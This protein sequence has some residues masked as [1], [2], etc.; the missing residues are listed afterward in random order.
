MSDHLSPKRAQLVVD[1]LADQQS[2][3]VDFLRQLTRAESPSDVPAT[4]TA[5]LHLLEVFLRSID[6]HVE[7]VAG[8]HTGG[9]LV[10]QP[11]NDADRPQQLLVGHCDTVWPDGTLESMPAE[12]N[13]GRMTGPGVYDMKSGLV[14]MLFALKALKELDIDMELSPLVFINTDEEIGSVESRE[15]VHELAQRVQRAFVLE[16]SMGPSGKLKTTRKGV[17]RF[18]VTVKGKAAHAG[19]D[20]ESGASAIAELAVV[21]QQLFSLNDVAA[22][23]TVNVGMIEGGVRPNVIAPESKAVVDVR[24]RSITE[25]ARVEN[26]IRGLQPTTTDT[27]IHVSGGMGRPPMEPT[28][29][30]QQLW[31]L[32]RDLGGLIG[33]ELEQ[34]AAGGGSDGNLTSQHTA[35]LDGLGGVGDGAHAV[36]EFVEVEE[37]PRRCALLALLLAAPDL[38]NQ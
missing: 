38:A 19:L 27:S 26:A 24:V 30:N 8:V 4:Q 35:T 22:G 13:E 12:V 23:T 37:L 32:A 29:R 36:H 31:N 14:Q 20:P 15:H 5:V 18:E 34:G 6:L 28:A 11:A 25:G 7:H 16:P 17:G 2:A 9:F 3:M 1:H 10:A 21:I 33:L